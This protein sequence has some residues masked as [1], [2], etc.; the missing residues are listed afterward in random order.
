[1]FRL[2][3]KEASIKIDRLNFEANGLSGMRLL[4][5]GVLQKTPLKVGIKKY[6]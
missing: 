3:N 2:N 5:Q 4:G 1:M 6:N